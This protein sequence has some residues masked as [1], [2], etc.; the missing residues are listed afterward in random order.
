LLLAN[1]LTLAGILLACSVVTSLAAGLGNLPEIVPGALQLVCGVML[2]NL[3]P[4]SVRGQC[5]FLVLAGFGCL[6]FS[7]Q[8]I[9]LSIAFS[10]NQQMIA[11]LA[12]IGLLRRIP[13]PREDNELPVGKKA[14]WQ[15][16]FGI[17]WMG[18]AINISAM[19]IFADRLVNQDGRMPPFQGV[20][21]ARGQ[22]LAALWSPF[23]V[24]MAVVLTN[25]PGADY[26]QLLIW[27]LPLSQLLLVGMIWYT[28]LRYPEES[29]AFRGYPF[30]ATALTTPMSLAFAV[31]VGHALAPGISI[32]TL[33]TLV[34]PG[35][36]LLANRRN[37]PLQI[38]GQ[39]IGHDLPRMG[40]E[41]VL[42]S[43]AGILGAG[44]SSLAA[45]QAISLSGDY[46]Q[47]FLVMVGLAA[48]MAASSIGIHPVVG[49]TVVAGVL[50]TTDLPPDLL[51]MS[52][53][54]SW[55]LGVLINPISGIHLFLAG[56]YAFDGRN[57]WS[58]NLQF[59]AVGYLVCCAW[60]YLYTLVIR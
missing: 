4:V 5:L 53:L 46:N 22:A 60:L 25:A 40:P 29:A 57:A 2:W 14:L 42:F 55:G 56:R 36:A 8:A 39:Y 51:A 34:A 54:M 6:L 16:I 32:L 7:P 58:W 44:L 18:S 19:A 20:M 43:A 41:I 21:L 17:H 24:A 30:R 38:L 52:F 27:G 15:T 59:A 11:M 47:L 50:T 35:Y 23:F 26:R 9:P 10:K 49:I 48:I 31:L 3:V 1:R 12:G 13:I 37:R 28:T 33:I 45:G